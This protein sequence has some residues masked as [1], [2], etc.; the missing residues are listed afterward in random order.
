[1]SVNDGGVIVNHTEVKRL[2]DLIRTSCK[3]RAEPIRDGCQPV[4]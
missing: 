4:Q 2:L 3:G 1:M